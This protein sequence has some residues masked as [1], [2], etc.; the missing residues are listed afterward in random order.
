MPRAKAR[1]NPRPHEADA[2]YVYVMARDDGVT[3]IGVSR[4]VK[5]RMSGIQAATPDRLRLV[6]HERPTSLTAFEVE[7]RAMEILHY[8]HQSG[9]WFYC[10]PGLAQLAIRAAQTEEPRLLAFFELWR[11]IAEATE[12]WIVADRHGVFARKSRGGSAAEDRVAASQSERADSG[13]RPC[14]VQRTTAHLVRRG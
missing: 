12:A 5:R 14:T 1:L 11:R 6:H 3:K 9:E 2:R 7:R 8:W 4:H 10:E 13:C